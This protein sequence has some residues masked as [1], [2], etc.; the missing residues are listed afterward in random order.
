M[1]VVWV[2]LAVAMVV[3]FYGGVV[4]AGE[5]DGPISFVPWKVL[6]PGDSPP[7]SPLILYWIPASPEDFRHSDLLISRP[8][9]IFASQCVAMSVVRPDDTAR[10]TTL[11]AGALPAAIL[12]ES[13]GTPLGTVQADRGTLHVRDVERLVRDKLA[14]RRAAI[15]SQVDDARK[16]V[17]AGDIQSAINTYRA[18][19][20]QR[21]LDPRRAREAQRELKRLGVEVTSP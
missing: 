15:E 13:G 8:L 7:D 10:I 6:A 18:V 2:R 20:S 3:L 19:W 11:S 21:C 4:V 16:K 9:T 1:R 14:D 12:V 5:L 17:R